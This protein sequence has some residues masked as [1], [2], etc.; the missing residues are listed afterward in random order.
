MQNG[1]ETGVDGG[2]VDCVDG[3]SLCNNGVQDGNETDG[4]CGG[5]D[6]APCPT[7]SD[8]IQN[9]SETDGDCGGPDCVDC[10]SN[11]VQD[12]D[13]TDVD[14]GGPVSSTY[15]TLCGDF[16][17]YGCEA[18]VGC[19]GADCVDCASLCNNGVQDGTAT[20]GDFGWLVCYPYPSFIQATLYGSQAYGCSAC[21]VFQ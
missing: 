1:S 16:L 3:A 18:G 13:E 4:D 19:G 8:G 12:G 5:V 15:A 6:C 11:G 7:C 10:C 20:D 2:G 14:C 17:E 21:R 9:G